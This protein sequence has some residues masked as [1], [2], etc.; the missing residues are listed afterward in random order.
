MRAI[1]PIRQHSGYPRADRA[2]RPDGAA[3]A[4]GS[5]APGRN[6]DRR[7]ARMGRLV[8]LLGPNC[9][10]IDQLTDTVASFTPNEATADTR[11]H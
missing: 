6:V 7:A 1:A 5:T 11:A 2:I 8:E 10:D 9:D 4:C 3:T